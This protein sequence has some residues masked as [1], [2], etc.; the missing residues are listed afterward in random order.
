MLDFFT[1]GTY[2][3]EAKAR[4]EIPHAKTI[5]HYQKNKKF[6]ITNRA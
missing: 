3:K 5:C 6:S 2:L 4:R 1:Q